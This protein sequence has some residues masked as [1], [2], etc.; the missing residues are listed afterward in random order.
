MTRSPRPV[1]VTRSGRGHLSGHIDRYRYG[2][3]LNRRKDAVGIIDAILK[4]Q[5]SGVRGKEGPHLAGGGFGADRLHAKEDH[6]GIAQAVCDAGGCRDGD[7]LMHSQSVEQQ[8]IAGD[9]LYV[10]CAADQFDAHAGTGQ[11]RSEIA[12]DGTRAHYRDRRP[13]ASCPHEKTSYRG[14]LDDAPG[15]GMRGALRWSGRPPPIPMFS[16]LRRQVGLVL[17]RPDVSC[18][19]CSRATVVLAP[20]PPSRDRR[21]GGFVEITTRSRRGGSLSVSSSTPGLWRLSFGPRHPKK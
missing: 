20:I 8:S 19:A 4:T 15:V 1:W 5:D 13:M 3:R 6:A 2:V 21:K 10:R 16:A 12:P 11:H 7:A 9:R 17:T 18:R 14:R